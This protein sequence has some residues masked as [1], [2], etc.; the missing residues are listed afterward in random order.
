L[1]LGLEGVPD[2]EA[3]VQAKG[4]AAIIVQIQHW[5]QLHP[6]AES[7]LL[8][9]LST[10]NS[11]EGSSKGLAN[12]VLFYLDKGTHRHPGEKGAYRV[13]PPGI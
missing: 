6:K 7:A 12:R 8:R 10:D 4:R 5:A 3:L 13:H 1:S 2:L 9:E 11:P